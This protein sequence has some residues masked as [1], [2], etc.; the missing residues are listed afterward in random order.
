MVWPITKTRRGSRQYSHVNVLIRH[1]QAL[2]PKVRHDLYAELKL[3][4][5]FFATFAIGDEI[6]VA[7]FNITEYG[8]NRLVEH[9]HIEYDREYDWSKA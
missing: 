3:R 6:V 5:S 1:V 2:T 4:S 9:F 7:I 8:L